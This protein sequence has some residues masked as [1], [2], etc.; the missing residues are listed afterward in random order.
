MQARLEA[1][2]RNAEEE[3][4]TSK[5]AARLAAEQVFTLPPSVR[6]CVCDRWTKR[7]AA[8]LAIEFPC[9]R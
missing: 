4:S 3:I 5:A 9:C 2:L 7:V 1:N 8:S 6:V